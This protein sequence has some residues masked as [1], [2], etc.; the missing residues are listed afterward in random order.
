V[1][2]DDGALELLYAELQAGDLSDQG[3]VRLGQLGPE[4]AAIGRDKPPVPASG[5][6]SAVDAR[7]LDAGNIAGTA[8][9]GCNGGQH[10]SLHPWDCVRHPTFARRHLTGAEP[11]CITTLIRHTHQAFW[12]D[13]CLFTCI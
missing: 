7:H 6:R 8:R 9:L 5:K 12:Y 1:A 13:I 3:L 10:A 2:G 11:T 4:L